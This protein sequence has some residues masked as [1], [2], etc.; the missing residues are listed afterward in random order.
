MK[1][2]F[3][4]LPICV[5]ALSSCGFSGNPSITP[6]TYTVIWENYNG[7]VLEKDTEVKEGTMPEYN[8]RTPTRSSD[9]QYSYSF[10]DWSPTLAK[11][12]KDIT[13][14]AQYNST[15]EKAKIVFDLD[16]G[17]T[18]H[19][20]ASIY[21]S[22]I[23]ASDFF[24]DVN[25]EGYNFRGWT[26]KGQ[27]VFD[28]NG[29]KKYSPELEEIMTFKAIYDQNVYV[30]V[31]KNIEEAGT[32]TGEGT[33]DRN[34]TIE[35]YAEPNDGYY[36]DGWY[37]NKILIS[38]NQLLRYTVED[39]DVELTAKFSLNSYQLDVIS[40][41]PSLGSVGIENPKA[42]GGSAIVKY[43]TEVIVSAQSTQS[44][45]DFLGWY[46]T[47]DELVSRSYVYNFT[48]PSHDLELYAKW[49]A[50]SYKV[51]V[52]K[53]YENAGAITGDGMHEYST[54]V[55][56]SQTTNNGY[57]FDG[58][59]YKDNKV[60]QLEI[61][62]FTMPKENVT[63]EARWNTVTYNITYVLN[64]GTNSSDNP[65]T[66]SVESD[67][68]LESPTKIGYTFDGWTLDEKT[69]THIGDGMIGDI[70]LVANW[71]PA[72]YSITLNPN[73]GELEGL[74]FYATYDASYVLP[75]PTRLGY[76]FN[77]WQNSGSYISQTG[78]WKYTNVSELIAQ[79]TIINYTISYTL[80]GGT[81]NKS[82]PSKYTV[83]DSVTFADPTKTGHTFLGWYDGDDNKV[84]LIPI[85]STGNL[86]LTAHWNDGDYFN[87]TLN[88][89][90]GDVLETSILVQ[91]DHEYS[92]PTPT[93]LGYAFD[94]WFDDST[95]IN[96]EGTWK[97]TS[98]KTFVAQWTIITYSINY[99]V[100]GGINNPSNPSNYTV[101][102]SV[103]F[104]AP[105]KTG[106][107]F[108]GWYSNNEV[109]RGIPA[110]STG[111]FIVEARWSANLNTLS[112]TSVDTTKGN[113]E[114][115]SGS[116]YSDE[117]ITV[118]ATPVGDCV[119]KGWYHESTKVSD[120]ATYTFTMP[121]NDYS[122]VA[123]FFTKAE[124]ELRRLGGVPTLSDDGKTITY[125]LYPQKNV[126]D[127]SLIS[128]L[129]ALTTPESNGWYLY[130][131]DYY[132]KVTATLHQ[133]GCK[134]DNG[135]TISS[136][137]TYWFK[138][139]PIVWNVLS[140]NSGEYYIVSSV[141]LDVHCY[142]NSTSNR[143]IDGQTVYPN[144][145]K[146]SDIRAWLNEDFYN[147]AFALGNEHIQTTTV[148]NS[149]AT[150]NST[151]NSYACANTEDKVF[152]PSYKDYINSSYGF[153][154]STG[155]TDTRCCRTTDWARAR[156]AAYYYTS[157]GSYQYN[158]YYWT[159]SPRSGYSYYAWGVSY[160]GDLSYNSVDFTL[161]SVR[162]GLS[163]KIA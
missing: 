90:G 52:I 5:L 83:E 50:P 45:Y 107:A 87:I 100:N 34:S 94:G 101:E 33:F 31:I 161:G 75:T 115:T 54:K 154:T 158:G 40:V 149:A 124:E 112:V 21:K 125:G 92:L 4:L 13:Y 28:Q 162:P 153:S 121:T 3:L 25:K 155:S 58:W 144:N 88:P 70:T 103:T 43:K 82:N 64:G 19:S 140:N 17:V 130:N 51:I 39:S 95:K 133:S 61:Y 147:S 72:R 57:A 93:R 35:L 36:F 113:V 145:Y 123:H 12:Y 85:G 146:Y 18:E 160:D 122:L 117:Q 148:D 44:E 97:Y 99:E 65:K 49:D 134:F 128:A 141:L 11:V 157:S 30:K 60:G 132:A 74:T 136:G 139:E 109:T 9:E 38:N 119:F 7:E 163:I 56:L 102:D 96:N 2:R 37:Y 129:N 53:N 22:S 152:L 46:S 106:Y 118:V 23:S 91:Y 116:G 86:S 159:R 67:I 104:A 15:L 131:K 151:S 156:G 143:T 62:R 41:H 32:I 77:G 20:T 81:N 127:S 120:D 126:N 6:K 63:Y 8:G 55:T 108:T 26:Y 76:K 14:V 16:G 135:T 48:M 10:S 142:Y 1:K 68:D 29:N 59:Y 42:T 27:L 137:T 66:Y 98:N 114:I 150:T 89:N 73:G 111:T 78:T 24:F 79:W 138:C 80:N 69:I 84:A 105:T 71:L 47:D 110:G